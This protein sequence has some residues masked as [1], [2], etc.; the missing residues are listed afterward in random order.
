MNKAVILDIETDSV[1]PNTANPKVIGLMDV[2]TEK[3]FIWKFDYKNKTDDMIKLQDKLN[4]YDC[5]ITYNGEKFDIPILERFGLVI[6]RWKHKDLFV[7]LK[8]R[9]PTLIFKTVP[10]SFSLKNIIKHLKLDD[11]GKGDIDYDIFKKDIWTPEEQWEIVKYLS[12]DLK[13]TF[14]LW[15]FLLHK[16]ETFKEF[17]SEWKYNSYYHISSSAGA[18]AYEAICHMIGVEK[19]PFNDKK[20]KHVPYQGAFVSD[21]EKESTKCCVLYFDFASLYSMINIMGNLFSHSCDCC[22]IDEKW[23]G[24]DMFPNIKGHYCKKNQGK[25]ENTLKKIYLLRKEYKKNNDDRQAPLK[26]ILNSVY[27]I[28][29]NEAFTLLYNKYTAADCT[30]IGRRCIQYAREQFKMNSFMPLYSDTDSIFVEV[31]NNDDIDKCFLV[32]K[33]ISE[34]LMKSFPFPW[35]EF[36]L[37]IEDRIK[38]I[39]FFKDPSGKLKKKNY[40]YINN[41]NKITI[42]GIDIVKRNTSNLTKKIFTQL[43]QQIVRDLNCKFFKKYI[44]ELII[45]EIKINPELA[46]KKIAVKDKN[47]YCST[48][49]LQ[50]KLFEKYGEGEH[51]LVRNN[52]I[53]IGNDVKY[54]L[55]T[56]FMEKC[57]IYD[58]DINTFLDELRPFIIDFNDKFSSNIGQTLLQSYGFKTPI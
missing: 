4:E 48:T 14:K 3:I 33:N 15:T 27:G 29:G 44:I 5:I 11:V 28:S 53:G 35:E 32:A 51:L 8:Y 19:P 31:N 12:Q 6:P 49:S 22:D 18:Y 23:H 20:T 56:E 42:K 36:N 21:P 58:L 55:F 52:K 40:L 26:V 16:F 45:N 2:Q 37:K 50:Y 38:Y 17:I 24:N 46:I 34:T 1:D 30:Y 41:D 7:I 39:Q 13:L 54:C 10:E 47:C 57:S 43:K 9:R 25:I